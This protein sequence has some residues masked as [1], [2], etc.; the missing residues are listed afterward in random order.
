MNFC[1]SNPNNYNY[2][3]SKFNSSHPLQH[4]ESVVRSLLSRKDQICDEAFRVEEEKHVYDVL[5]QNDY[6]LDFLNR[7]KRKMKKPENIDETQNH[8][9]VTAP[10]IPT[11]SERISRILKPINVKLVHKPVNKLRNTL[12]NHKDRRKPQDQAGVIY[13]LECLRCDAAYIGE[14]GRVVK[15]RM[16]E[17]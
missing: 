14:T 7:V 12:C 5:S 16:E 3:N 4:K 2:Y 8:Q 15:E 11:V 6:P 9:F 1:M 17:H 13:R 10:Y